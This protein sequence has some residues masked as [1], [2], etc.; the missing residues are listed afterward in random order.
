MRLIPA[1]DIRG[2]KAVRLTEGDPE[3]QTVYFEDPVG[4]ALYWQ[5][6]G[7]DYLHVVDLDAAIGGGDNRGQISK[8]AQ[9]LSIPFEVGGGIR[10]LA[11]AEGVLHSGAARV[12]IG[13]TLVKD[14]QE[15]QRM[16]DSLGPERLLPSIDGRG[17]EVMVSGWREGQAGDVLQLVRRAAEMGFRT[18]IYTDVR[19]DGTLQGLD[20]QVIAR[21]REAWPHYLIAGGGVAS[22]EDV[23]GLQEL[24]VEAAIAGKALYEGVVDGSRW[25]GG[26]L[27]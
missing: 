13:T 9:V 1:V 19:R 18:L 22:D 21:V 8:I 24:G 26:S 15:A 27:D 7:A 10:S 17:L 11:E 20:L 12:I 25:W 5:S 16:L 23:L 14:P 6:Q 2:G 3:R 4:A